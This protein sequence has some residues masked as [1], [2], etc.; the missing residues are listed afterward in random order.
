MKGGTISVDKLGVVFNENRFQAI[1]NLSFEVKSSQFVTFLGTSGCG[2][3]TIL[4]VIAGFIAPTSGVVLFNQE[5]IIEPSWERGIVFQNYSLFPWLTVEG[6]TK[7]G[8]K[9]RGLP[10]SEVKERTNKFIDE[11][12]LTDFAT[13]YPSE[14]SGGMQQRVAL[15]RVLANDPSLLLMD[16]PFG[17]LDAQTR[18]TMQE[19]VLK[20]FTKHKKTVVFVTHDVDE[21]ILLSDIVFILTSA[22]ASIKSRIEITLPRP[23]NHNTLI[24]ADFIKIKR[25]IMGQFS[26]DIPWV[27]PNGVDI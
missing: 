24:H 15:A 12:G 6:N 14:L 23:R 3:S 7:Y 25:D 4:N 26:E 5:P 20:I 9:S 11:V 13:S 8:L 2:K 27:I 18:V 22:P 16:E 1:K 10:K 17:A 21:A 19:L